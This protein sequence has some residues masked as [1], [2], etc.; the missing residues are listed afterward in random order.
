MDRWRRVCGVAMY[1]RGAKRMSSGRIAQI[2]MRV[3]LQC[4]R[5]ALYLVVPLAAIQSKQSSSCFSLLCCLKC[6]LLNRPGYPAERSG[7]CRLRERSNV[8]VPDGVTSAKTDPL[9]DGSVL[10]LGSGEL[11]FR[12]EGLVALHPNHRQYLSIKS[13]SSIPLVMFVSFHQHRPSHSAI[14]VARLNVCSTLI[15]ECIA[16]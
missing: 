7:E 6:V 11:N 16:G 3:F 8:C 13:S 5:F 10:L 9:W 1:K 15:E 4:L 2:P 12:A 14:S